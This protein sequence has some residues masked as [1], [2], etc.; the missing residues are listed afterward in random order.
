[1]IL[2]TYGRFDRLMT[3]SI[4]LFTLLV[5]C[6]MF[7]CLTNLAFSCLYHTFECAIVISG[8]H[9]VDTASCRHC[10]KSVNYANEH[11]C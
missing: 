8:Q 2:I 11:Q 1:M 3:W 4:V 6:L 5:L 10:A 9:H 7:T